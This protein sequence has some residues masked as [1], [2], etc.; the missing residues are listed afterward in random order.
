MLKEQ[1]NPIGLRF[2]ALY[3]Q[4]FEEVLERNNEKCVKVQCDMLV[5]KSHVK[6]KGYVEHNH[7]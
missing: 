4:L 7:N 6:T 1:E 5:D 3:G 2:V